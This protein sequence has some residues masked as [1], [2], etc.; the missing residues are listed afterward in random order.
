MNRKTVIALIIGVLLTA[1]AVQNVS[2]YGYRQSRIG[3]GVGTPNA[4]IIYRPAPFDFRFGYDFSEGNQF[5]FLSGDWRPTGNIQINGPLYFYFGIGG[6]AKFYPE[7]DSSEDWFEGGTRL[8]L[9]L[10]L[11]FLDNVGELFIEVAPGF[12]LYPKPA[13]SDDPVQVWAGLT[14]AIR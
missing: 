3:F 8:P 13:F 6:Y 9:G 4:V 5:I 1:V 2:A 14:F 12:D 10:S 11:M 7:A